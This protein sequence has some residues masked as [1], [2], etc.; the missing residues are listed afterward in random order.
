[1][2]DDYGTDVYLEAM[3]RKQQDDPR[4][5]PADQE[6]ISLLRKLEW[7]DGFCPACHAAE[8]IDRLLFARSLGWRGRQVGHTNDCII[9]KTIN[10]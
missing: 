1:M 7:I 6:I 8:S 5:D 2:D 4:G 9:D 10:V 3:E